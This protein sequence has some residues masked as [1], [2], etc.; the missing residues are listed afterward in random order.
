M[1]EITLGHYLSLSAIIFSIGVTSDPTEILTGLF[2]YFC[3]IL[4]MLFGK[5]AENK[6]VWWFFGTNFKINSIWGVK[7][8]SS[9]LS[10]SSNTR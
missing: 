10:V 9:I 3:E 8:I 6:R 4:R 5:V 1:I 7:P 2:K